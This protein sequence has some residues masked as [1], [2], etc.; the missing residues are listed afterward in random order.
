M[1]IIQCED[2]MMFRFSHINLSMLYNLLSVGKAQM[3]VFDAILDQNPVQSFSAS[4][5]VIAG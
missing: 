5:Y 1:F 3:F 4:L 2:L